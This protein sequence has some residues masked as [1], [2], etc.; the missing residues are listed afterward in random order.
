MSGPALTTERLELWQ[1]AA[2]DL[3]QLFAL[4]ED[5]QTRRFLGSSEPSMGDS[6][7]RLHRN[8]GSW[9]LHGYGVFMVRLK[10]EAAIIGTCGVFHS[11]RDLPGLNDVP[12]AGWIVRRDH[13]GKGIASEAMRASLAWFDG[14]QGQQRIGCMIEEGNVASE[15]LALALGFAEYHRQ[16]GDEDKVMVL[17]ERVAPIGPAAC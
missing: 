2:D 12:E 9:A 14:V 8:A 13:W 4:T 6:F 3:D 11:W 1:P 10:G 5:D 17:Y 16:A 15:K 7:A